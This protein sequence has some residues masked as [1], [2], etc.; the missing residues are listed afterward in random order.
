MGR[1]TDARK[2]AKGKARKEDEPLPG[3]PDQAIVFPEESRPASRAARIALP[4]S[5]L[6]A[7]ILA[8][9]DAAA[10]SPAI[11]A[12][13]PS[14]PTPEPSHAAARAHNISF[15]AS[16]VREERKVAEAT[17]HLATFFLSREEYGVDVRL[18]QEIIRVTEITPVPRAPESIKGVINLRGRVIPVI[19]LK[20]KLG[21]GD[22]DPGRRARIVV[23]KLRDRLVGLLVD[24]ASQ[25][26]KVPVSSIDPAPDAVVEIDAD[27][28]RGVAKLPDRLI[29]LMDLQKIL[30]L[31]LREGGAA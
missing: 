21:L 12:S 30:S 23:V 5:G 1:M 13:D 28:I 8:M 16:P 17:E 29:I 24:A 6:A 15:F 7:D 31:E 3:E 10:V 26:L 9:A 2:R 19:D 25:V 4:P 14:P 22:V 20:R 11:P 18:V 27:Y